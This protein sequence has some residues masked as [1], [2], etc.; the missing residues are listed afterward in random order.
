GVR[1]PPPPLPPP[2][3]DDGI[4]R[5]ATWW[6]WDAGGDLGTAW[7]T[8]TSGATGWRSGRGA[9]GYGESYLATPVGYGPDANSKYITTYF[10]TT[11]QVD[12]PAAVSSMIAEVMYDDGFVAYLNGTEVARASMPAG[13]I[14]AGTLAASHEAGNAYQQFDWS[15]RRDLLHAGTNVLAVEVH[16]VAAS[17]SD[18]VFDLALQLGSQPPPPPTGDEDIP[19]GSTW[20]YWDARQPPTTDATWTQPG[21][22]DGAW[23]AGPGPLGYGETYIVTPL[24]YG[25]DPTNKPITTYFRHWFDA[26]SASAALRAELMYDDGVVVYLNGHEITR[27][28]MPTGTI[29]ST[30]HSTGHETGNAYESYDWTAFNSYLVPGA[31]LLAVEVHQA[32]PTSS[33]LTFDLALDVTSP[34]P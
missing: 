24:S 21:Y 17:S 28:Y 2:S 22:S 6:Y 33:D 32:A 27:L 31:N 26:A 18:L 29:D 20:R 23:A 14:T 34:S 8:Q 15:A 1:A 11:T 12:D 19:R 7:R 10:T 30:T 3:N 4:P 9:L 25:T 13:A 16:Q 5:N